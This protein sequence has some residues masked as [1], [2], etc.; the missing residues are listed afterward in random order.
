MPTN[1]IGIA[2]LSETT[3]LLTK[4]ALQKAQGVLPDSASVGVR[5]GYH[6][7]CFFTDDGKPIL[8]L[9]VAGGNIGGEPLI[10]VAAMDG[11]VYVSPVNRLGKFYV[12][13]RRYYKFTESIYL[14]NRDG[15]FSGISGTTAY[16]QNT[17]KTAKILTIS[18]N[19]YILSNEQCWVLRGDGMILFDDTKMTCTVD[20]LNAT[21]TDIDNETPKL[22]NVG[23]VCSVLNKDDRVYV[24]AKSELGGYGAPS[25]SV[26]V[27]ETN[28][29]IV[30]GV[31]GM[32][33][34]CS[35]TRE[36]QSL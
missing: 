30:Y 1:K 7:H 13:D 15:L 32:T 3:S 35:I 9:H 27:P 10:I 22:H 18:K 31:K 19:I 21:I 6:V 28:G 8:P 24:R 11:F 36:N 25:V 16:N 12:L 23:R 17:S 26:K 20:A 29:Y 4:D 33:N 2:N 5:P 34:L 14:F